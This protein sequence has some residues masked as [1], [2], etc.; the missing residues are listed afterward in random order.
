MGSNGGRPK[1]PLGP[2]PPLIPGGGPRM[3]GPGGPLIP[4]GPGPGGPLNRGGPLGPPKGG[5]PLEKASIL[6]KMLSTFIV[7]LSTSVL[8]CI[9]F[10]ICTVLRYLF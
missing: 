7:Y 5:P 8:I 6:N 10:F 4:G 2:G 1:G 9:V 3:P